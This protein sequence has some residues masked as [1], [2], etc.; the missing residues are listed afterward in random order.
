LKVIHTT[1]GLETQANRQLLSNCQT[2]ELQSLVGDFVL[3]EL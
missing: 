2:N 3:V 1:S